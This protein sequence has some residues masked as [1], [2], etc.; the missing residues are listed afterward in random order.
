MN[1]FKVLSK[2]KW[3][4]KTERGE[5]EGVPYDTKIIMSL[6]EIVPSIMLKK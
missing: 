6:L 2:K 3:W 5:S 1:D 4:D